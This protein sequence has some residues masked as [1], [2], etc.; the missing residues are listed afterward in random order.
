[1]LSG[2]IKFKNSETKFLRQ[3][4]LSIPFVLMSYSLSRLYPFS[5]YKYI[6]DRM[7]LFQNSKENV[8]MNSAV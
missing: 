6:P 5:G 4:K 7:F 1:M 2:F 8:H 3:K